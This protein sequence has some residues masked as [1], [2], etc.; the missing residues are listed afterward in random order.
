MHFR[1]SRTALSHILSDTI[2]RGKVVI[3][4]PDKGQGV[5][6]INKEDYI[7]SMEKI[8][9]DE[10]KFKIVEK[11]PTLI[12]INTIKSY[13]NTM[14]KR[15]EI[16]EEE[17]KLMRPQGGNRARARGLLKIH[18]EYASLPKFRPIIDTI[19]TPYYG[20]GT[21]LKNLLNLLTVNEFT[22]K[23]SFDAVS[24][25]QNIPPHIFD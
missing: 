17:K 14:F 12:R 10:K 22:V 21:F 19:G 8:F 7:T 13:I 16:N 5:V 18:K 11:D 23:Y 15:G 4:K 25:I 3:L 20:I 9:S 1:I 6:L 2:L 24:R